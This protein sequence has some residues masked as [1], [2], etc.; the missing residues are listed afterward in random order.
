MPNYSFN[1]T[2][3]QNV[4][5][6]AA[7]YSS[8]ISSADTP[9]RPGGYPGSQFAA[10]RKISLSG[11]LTAASYA[12][13][14]AAWSDL[15]AAHDV[16]APAPLLIRDGWYYLATCESIADSE[17]D[18]TSI[19]YDATYVC[20]DPFAFS[21][22]LSTPS[23]ATTGGTITAVAGN[24]NALPTLT[25]TV[26]AA[27]ASSFVTVTNTTTG[28]QFV[29]T[30]DVTGAFVID[31]L[32][33]TVKVGSTDKMSCFQGRFLSLRPGSNTLTITASNGATLSSATISYRA[34]AI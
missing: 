17:R 28:E 9:S 23:L 33:E 31:S 29:L 3:L 4:A 1:G 27:P 25:L 24:K 12:A 32:A 15:V 30:P 8:R 26:S 10:E 7:P 18:V 2:A 13:L 20:A 21:A 34:R 22:T 11:T 16:T 14:D 19:Q 5:M 6:V